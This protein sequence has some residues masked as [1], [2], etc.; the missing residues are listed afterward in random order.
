MADLDYVKVVGRLGIVVR[1]TAGDADT[2]PDTIWCDEG[3]VLITPLIT[4]VKVV[5]ATPS[6]ATLGRATIVANIDSEGYLSYNG[7]QHIGVED[8]TSPKVN[9]SIGIGKSTHK[10]EFVGLAADGIPVEL[11]SPQNLRF[12]ADTA[13]EDGEC[14]IT[15]LLPLPVSGGTSQIVGPRGISVVEMHTENGELIYTLSDSTEGNAGALPVGPQGPSN[16]LLYTDGAYPER[17]STE[18]HVF[19]GPVDP[20]SLDL[21][22]L[23]DV[24]VNNDESDPENLPAYVFQNVYDVEQELKADLDG[25][26]KILEEQIPKP[27]RDWET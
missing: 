26:G 15:L 11:P 21:M 13:N 3:Q 20:D 22:L 7:V 12:A 1:D 18:P 5:D 23:G 19:V 4:S 16:F 6:P 14:D 10:I 24:W 25:G 9:P 27:D 2:D 8:L 17:N